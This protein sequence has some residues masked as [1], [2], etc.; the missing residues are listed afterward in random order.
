MRKLP[1][2][3]EVEN[4]EDTWYQ[5]PFNV[6]VG[7]VSVPLFAVFGGLLTA[8]A[9]VTVMALH[10]DVFLAGMAWLLLGMTTYVVYR[11][12]KGL[13]LTE[14]HMVRLPPPAGV[15]PVAYEGV[16]VAFE[17]GTYSDRAMATAL[18]LAAHRRSEV[19]VVVTIEVPTHLAI[20]A[21]LPEAELNAGLV[22][23]TA[24]QWAARGQRVRGQIERVRVGEA[25]HR[26]VQIARYLHADAI[27]MPMPR[28]R[29]PGK[30]LSPALTVVLAKRP[31]RVIIDSTSAERIGSAA[32]PRT[33][34]AE[35][36]PALAS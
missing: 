14:T 27:V 2:D 18:K 13:S 33:P 16:I 17:E 30:L 7:G 1:G 19:R 15:A 31:C 24:R 29:P 9:W 23:E 25:G 22:I 4:G 12:S 11:K 35:R 36:E 28:R 34:V 21:D 6:T 20:D 8:T 3:V 32:V 10:R 26:I 5:A